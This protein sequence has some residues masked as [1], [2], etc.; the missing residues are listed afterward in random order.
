MLN[1]NYNKCYYSTGANK[2]HATC[3]HKN[4]CIFNKNRI[5]LETRIHQ[6][7][8]QLTNTVNDYNFIRNEGTINS[9]DYETIT[10]K[11]EILHKDYEKLKKFEEKI[12]ENG[13]NNYGYK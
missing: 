6:L 9:K 7:K 5:I 11:L 10:K 13:G 1:I 3:T 8:K 12:K 2:P 4:Y